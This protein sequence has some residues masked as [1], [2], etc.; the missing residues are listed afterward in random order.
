[1]ARSRLSARS[2]HRRD[3]STV[4]EGSV[5]AAEAEAEA[6]AEQGRGGA[7]AG[8]RLGSSRPRCGALPTVRNREPPPPPPPPLRMSAALRQE[9]QGRGRR[10]VAV[11]SLALSRQASAL[12]SAPG[13]EHR[14]LELI[15]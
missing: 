8:R 11:V 4:V 3:G 10:A 2:A 5:L 15:R 7:R 14:S 12:G 9:R 13:T 1:M 6:E